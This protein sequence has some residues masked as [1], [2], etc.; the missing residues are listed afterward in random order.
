VQLGGRK[1]RAVLALLVLRAGEVVNDDELIDALWEGGSAGSGARRSLQVYVS[2]LRNA[3]GRERIAR[4]GPGYVLAAEPDEVDVPVFERLASEGR[5]RLAGGRPAEALDLLSQALA[6]WH[7]PALSDFAYESWA[8]N[9]A[10]RLDE[11]RLGAVEARLAAELDLGRHAEL[12]PELESLLA[13]HPHREGLARQLMLA[14]YRSGRQ[15]DA[16]DV[17]QTAR[18]RLVDELGIDPG[19]DLQ[20]LYKAILNQDPE[21][22]PTADPVR[23]AGNLPTPVSSFIGRE[24]DLAEAAELMAVTRMLTVTGPGGAGKTRFVRELAARNGTGFEEGTFWVSLA[25]LRDARLVLDSVAQALGAS[26]TL[27]T[28]IADKRMLVVLDNFEQVIDAASGVSALLTA[29]PHLTVIATSRELLRI[30]G[31]VEYPLPPLSV[32]DGTALFC[33]RARL[34]ESEPISSLCS[35]L[36]GLPLAIELAAARTSL[37]SPQQLLDRL[38]QRLDLLRGG[39]DVEPRQQTLRTTI[40]WS[41]DLLTDDER[42]AFVRL[43]VF[44]GGC[45]LEAAEAV[46]EADLET[47]A[48]LLDKNLVRRRDGRIVML[49]TI[50]EFALDGLEASGDADAIALRHLE[51]CLD[52]AERAAPELSGEE[53]VEWLATLEREHGNLRAALSWAHDVGRIEYALRLTSALQSLW[54]MHGHIDEGRRWFELAQSA[55]EGQAPLLRA[56]ILRGTNVFAATQDDWTR[57][58]ELLSEALTLYREVG[59]RRGTA[60]ALRDSG[61]AALRRGDYE[62]ARRCYE[63]SIAL[64]RELDDRVLLASTIT[65][66]GDLSLQVGDFAEASE[67][68]REA[69]AIQRELGST[70]YVVV[71]LS[72][73]GFTC[74]HAREDE[75][76]R[77]AFEECALL[78]HDVGS[79]DN[80][81]YAFEG[82]AA[83]AARRGDWDLTS[84]LLGR[85]EAIREKIATVLEPAEQLVH[86]ETTALLAAARSDDA[87]V[88][89][90]AAGRA[91]ADS[92]AIRRA[93]ALKP[94]APA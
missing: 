9:D 58:E 46:C 63:E 72:N 86:D 67:R 47:I 51:W 87:I 81:G 64:F 93:F 29:C 74:L 23:P 10:R 91:M 83:V 71:S 31:E 55:S 73:L 30:Q 49:E 42:T 21:L 32:D 18:A 15:A 48:S 5:G 6:L 25:A 80:L 7:G 17:Y 59:D 43:A 35:R 75:D 84:L 22:A 4:R 50:R 56:D 88:E 45:T 38:S 82:L 66:L 24:K 41:Y 19:A 12:V 85:A 90:L 79:T 11:A 8:Q 44:I 26:G 27:E 62:R 61:V 68:T 2:N 13:E 34:D 69:L 1:Q 89:G 57:S 33:A 77:I 14:L 3:L 52:L 60:L 37:L 92:D 70:F 78:A 36:D 39:R 76:A 54:Y 16:L 28:E 65:N 53:Q 94:A 20:E 40:A